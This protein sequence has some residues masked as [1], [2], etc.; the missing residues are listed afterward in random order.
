[1]F[2]FFNNSI[3]LFTYSQVPIQA[4]EDASRV[5]FSTND[6]TTFTEKDY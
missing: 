1:M 4:N 6:V 5:F 2:I 3:W